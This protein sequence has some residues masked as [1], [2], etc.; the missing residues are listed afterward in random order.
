MK[1]DELKQFVDEMFGVDP[2]VESIR[3]LIQAMQEAGEKGPTYE[4]MRKACEALVDDGILQPAGRE[5][6]EST[7][8]HLTENGHDL[9]EHG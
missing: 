1:L 8:E 5:G 4:E 2:E 7:I 3:G 9:M 6:F